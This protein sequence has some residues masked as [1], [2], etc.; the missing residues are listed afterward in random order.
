VSGNLQLRILW[1]VL[2][3]FIVT[4]S[5]LPGRTELYQYIAGYYSNS[6]VHFAGFGLVSAIPVIVSKRRSVILLSLVLAL[7]CVAIE[8]VH[9]FNPGHLT[10]A[11]YTV[12]NLFGVVAGL[13]FG[14]NIRMLIF[15]SARALHSGV[16]RSTAATG[17]KTV[18][19]NVSMGG[20]TAK[21]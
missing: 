9:S 2:V 5:L 16:V 4:M 19:L 7:L 12:P 21:R 15:S 14:C 6:W 17:D 18:S 10:R 1:F 3:G 20:R 11:Q 13:L 8:S